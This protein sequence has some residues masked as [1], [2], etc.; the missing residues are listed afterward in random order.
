[1]YCLCVNGYCHRVSTQL[2][3]TNLSISMSKSAQSVKHL[4]LS[5]LYFP[6][7]FTSLSGKTMEMQVLK[8]FRAQASNISPHL[9]FLFKTD[10]NLYLANLERR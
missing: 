5:T 8:I 1:M 3:L 6:W 4:A 2:Q 9:S 7:I 10:H